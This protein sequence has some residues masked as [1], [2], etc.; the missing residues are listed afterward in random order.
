MKYAIFDIDGT[1]SDA[2]ERAAKYLSDDAKDWDAFYGACDL[3][4]PIRPI[5]ELA[6]ALQDHYRILFV[7]GRRSAVFGK[8]RTWLAANAPGLN[9]AGIVMRK[10]G[11]KR[12]DKLVKPEILEDAMAELGFG[13]DDVAFIVEDRDSMVEKWRELGYTVLQPARGSF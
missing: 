1:I 4:K 13:K 12:H 8:T 9:Y 7:T 2:S 6:T 11:D 3:D 10:P 5:I